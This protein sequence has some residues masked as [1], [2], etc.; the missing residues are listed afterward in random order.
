MTCIT[1]FTSQNVIS[2]FKCIMREV[3]FWINVLNVISFIAF[4]IIASFNKAG[5]EE[6]KGAYWVTFESDSSL[7]QYTISLNNDEKKSYNIKKKDELKRSFYL[8]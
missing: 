2:P 7:E 3:R 8:T 4:T 6:L 5:T 1:L